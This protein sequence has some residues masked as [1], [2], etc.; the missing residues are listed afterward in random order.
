M[1]NKNIK[2]CAENN[3]TTFTKI[4]F[5]WKGIWTKNDLTLNLIKTKKHK[6]I[7]KLSS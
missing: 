1:N 2:S 7:H 6:K 3:A 4:Q 5:E